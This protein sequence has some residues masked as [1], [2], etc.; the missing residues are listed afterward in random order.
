MI[1]I[2][3]NKKVDM[4]DDEFKVYQEIC[5]SYD[6]PNFQGKDLFI[7]L[8][9]TDDAGRIMFL[10]PPS[11]RHTSLEVYLF[12]ATIQQ[13]QILRAVQAKADSL[14]AEMR[15]KINELDAKIKSV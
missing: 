1:K 2:I 3:D 14:F 13:Q 11:T 6:R 9:E 8:M 10:R 7:G 4:T 5:K 12:C 15:S